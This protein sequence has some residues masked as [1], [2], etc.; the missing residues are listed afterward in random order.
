MKNFIKETINKIIPKEKEQEQNNETINIENNNKIDEN[1]SVNEENKFEEENKDE[2]NFIEHE[3]IKMVDPNVLQIDPEYSKEYEIKIDVL[4]RIKTNMSN[5]G[6]DFS[7][8]IIVYLDDGKYVIV[9]GHT[10]SRAAKELGIKLVAISIKNFKDRKEALAYTRNRQIN[11]RNLSDKELLKY[12]QSMPKKKEKDGQKGR[13]NELIAKQLNISP[14]KVTQ[15]KYVEKYASEEDK[16]AINNDEKSNNEVYQK[17]RE[18]KKNKSKDS[19]NEL[20]DSSEK[21]INN[22]KKIKKDKVNI[23]DILELLTKHN[24]MNSLKI[25][26]EIYI[27]KFEACKKYLSSVK[28]KNENNSDVK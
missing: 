2:L 7:E 12:I 15:L 3:N 26:C 23:D 6:Y 25:I 20:I 18:E 16:E 8:P 17:L 13:Q 24:E 27:D 9:D 14:A 1:V 22:K 10:R 21:K 11:R 28:S 19:E 4:E 5:T